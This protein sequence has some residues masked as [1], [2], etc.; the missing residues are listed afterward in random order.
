MCAAAAEASSPLTV[1]ERATGLGLVAAA[2]LEGVEGGSAEKVCE[3]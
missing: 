2:V 3:R 1:A